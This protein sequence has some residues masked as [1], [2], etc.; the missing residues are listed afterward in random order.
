[1]PKL[2]TPGDVLPSASAVLSG[3]GLISTT[4]SGDLFAQVGVTTGSGSVSQVPRWTVLGNVTATQGTA[5]ARDLRGDVANYQVGDIFSFPG[6]LPVGWSLNANGFD[7]EY[8]GVGAA[9]TQVTSF[10]VQR[11]GF[12]ADLANRTIATV[13][14]DALRNDAFGILKNDFFSSQISSFSNTIITQP[15]GANPPTVNTVPDGSIFIDATTADAG[16]YFAEYELFE[17]GLP[18]SNNPGRIDITVGLLIA[19]IPPVNLGIGETLDMSQ[20]INDPN[21][22]RTD[23]RVTG[24]A[25]FVS[26]DSGTEL[27]TGTGIGD[28]PNLVLEVDF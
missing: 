6:G 12:L 5:S 22:L 11:P 17:Q 21:N 26:Y 1:M 13:T 24:I 18:A 25:G 15:V 20:F 10:S 19:K 16:S 3:A 23:T 9:V 14:V 4:A 2:I 7:L 8:D 27:L 28:E